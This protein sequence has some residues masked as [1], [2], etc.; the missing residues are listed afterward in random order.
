MLTALI[1]KSPSALDRRRGVIEIDRIFEGADFFRAD[2]SDDV[3]RGERVGHVLAGEAARP[4]RC[5]IDI[6]LDL[7]EFAAKRIRHGRAGNGDDRNA[8]KVQ[9]EV[10]QP[11]LRQPFAGQ[12]ELDDRHRRGV[13]V[14]D[15]RR[16]RAGRHL[17][18]QGLRDRGHLRVGG[19]D[20]RAWLEKYLDDA[21]A[22]EGVGLDVLDVVDRRRQRALEL[23]HHAAR[24]LVRRQAGITPDR[25]DNR[26]ADFRKDV[27]R[28]AQSRQRPDEQQEESENDERV[29][30]PQGD[31]DDRSHSVVPLPQFQPRSPPRLARTS[32]LSEKLPLCVAP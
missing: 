5:R 8:H 19:A 23:R 24:H 12:G 31:P 11:L 27:D 4:H 14:Q 16:Q 13:V 7:A 30:T 9:A 29:R 18:Q 20:V 28:R 21:E 32:P 10:E 3:L 2:G 25:R 17:S 15:E 1:G 22:G 6:D 26:D